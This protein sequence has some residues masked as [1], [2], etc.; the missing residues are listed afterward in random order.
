LSRSNLHELLL[1]EAAQNKLAGVWTYWS[2]RILPQASSLRLFI[3][4]FVYLIP[5]SLSLKIGSHYCIQTTLVFAKDLLAL[6][7]EYWDYKFAKLDFGH[8][9]TVSLRF[10]FWATF[11]IGLS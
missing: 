4:L 10:G 7:H 2:D 5:P 11:C 8:F 9:S 3:Y 1:G 6:P